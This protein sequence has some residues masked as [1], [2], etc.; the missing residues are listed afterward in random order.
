MLKQRVLTALVLIPVVLLVIGY[1]PLPWLYAIFGG[2]ALLG[3]WEWTRL[4]GLPADS[5]LR[6]PYVAGS[7]VILLVVW[8]MRSDW[9][10]FAQFALL[11]WLIVFGLICTYPRVFAR[12][13]PG[14]ALLAV[15]GQFMWVPAI[16]TLALLRDQPDGAL[17]LIYALTLV[18]VADTGAYFAGRSFGRVKLAPAVSPGK[19]REGALGGLL[20]CVAWSVAGG[21]LVFDLR[22]NATLGM[23]CALSVF[24][25]A[26]SIVGDLGMSLFKR[27][28]GVKDSGSILPGHGGILDRVDSLFAAAPVFAYGLLLAGLWQ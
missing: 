15:I 24:V 22:W 27:L 9:Q 4:M 5:P 8:F 10:V 14:A 17:K 2:V 26:V 23:F 11:W 20:L 7:A 13:R 19:T 18:W 21:M 6:W 12:R 1:A 28:S 16:V 3:A 25:A